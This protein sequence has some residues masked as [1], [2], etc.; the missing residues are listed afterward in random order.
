MIANL[1]S[2]VSGLKH[3][4]QERDRRWDMEDA[5]EEVLHHLEKAKK[6]KEA[7][8][9]KILDSGISED[10]GCHSSG[11]DERGRGPKAP[12][13]PVWYKGGG[14]HGR[15]GNPTPTPGPS[16]RVRQRETMSPRGPRGVRY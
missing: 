16:R 11:C 10:K 12:E 3:P 5:A 15:P 6:K 1:A 13:T 9:K 7:L 4:V 8:K 2:T 14:T